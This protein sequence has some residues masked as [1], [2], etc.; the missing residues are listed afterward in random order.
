MEKKLTRLKAKSDNSV[1]FTEL[2]DVRKQLV[3]LKE[4][5]NTLENKKLLT[6][7]EVKFINDKF[8]KRF[9]YLEYEMGFVDCYEMSQIGFQITQHYSDL[10]KRY[11][12]LDKLFEEGKI[13][14]ETFNIAKLKIVE[15]M[16]FIKE[17]SSQASE[18]PLTEKEIQLLLYL[19]N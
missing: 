3:L 17:N 11:K 13:N 18:K 4:Y 16:K 6:S 14:S 1:V 12:T 15:D 2:Q 5:L 19:N 9:D 10:E 8:N 7:D